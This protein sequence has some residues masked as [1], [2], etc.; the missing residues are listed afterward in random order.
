MIRG[1]TKNFSFKIKKDEEYIDGSEYSE[2]EVQF[3]PQGFSS[4]VKKLKSKNEV[5]WIDDHFV[6]PLS[7][8]DTFTLNSGLVE[9]Q[10]RLFNNNECKATIVRKIIV[11]KVLSEDVLE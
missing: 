2:V 6:C 8:E 4:S 7:Q 9:I 11:G 3:N 5:S 10:V 1:E